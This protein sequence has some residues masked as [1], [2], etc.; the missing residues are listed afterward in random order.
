MCPVWCR[1]GGTQ[2]LV[3][4]EH[5]WVVEFG[6]WLLRITS[7]WGLNH[8]SPLAAPSGQQHSFIYPCRHG[9]TQ[10]ISRLVSTWVTYRNHV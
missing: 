10:S 8:P 4:C 6:E 7:R 3:S 5:G 1:N 9:G 2:Y